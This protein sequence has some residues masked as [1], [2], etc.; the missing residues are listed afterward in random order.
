MNWIIYFFGSG[1]AFFA[2]VVLILVAAAVLGIFQRKWS[3]RTAIL[4]AFIGLVLI[5][6]SATP[7]PYWFY[8]V[9]G[10]VF[11]SLAGRRTI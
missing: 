11:A 7:L 9:A 10:V 2:G 5:L 1:A 6:L 3:T 4:M 8:F